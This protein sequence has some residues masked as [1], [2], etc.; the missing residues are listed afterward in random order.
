MPGPVTQGNTFGMASFGVS[1]NMQ[2]QYI[3]HIA[4]LEPLI[5][6]EMKTSPFRGSVTNQAKLNPPERE[7]S[8]VVDTNL[9]IAGDPVPV[10]L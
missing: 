8:I 3:D 6:N 4:K 1:Q 9:V 2:T 7:L 10:R 5:I